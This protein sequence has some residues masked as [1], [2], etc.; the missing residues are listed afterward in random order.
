MDSPRSV[1]QRLFPKVCFTLSKVNY[2]KS[3]SFPRIATVL[4]C[5]II[6]FLFS[7]LSNLLLFVIDLAG[8]A[9]RNLMQLKFHFLTL[10]L[11]GTVYIICEINI[12]ISF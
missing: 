7:P 2:I 11:Y 1:E 3:M 10:L 9:K 8:N 5:L 6:V 4:R 12:V